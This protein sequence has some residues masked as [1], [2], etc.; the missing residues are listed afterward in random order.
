MMNNQNEAFLT[1]NAD[2]ED[3]EETWNRFSNDS[4]S[5]QAEFLQYT[6]NELDDI[7][8]DFTHSKYSL[9]EAVVLF[10]AK[11]P[12]NSTKNEIAFFGETRL[13]VCYYD[14]DGVFLGSLK[15]LYSIESV[16]FD[17]ITVGSSLQD[18]IALDPNGSY[19]FLYT[20]RND[21][22]KVS[23]HYTLDK[24]EVVITYDENNVVQEVKKT[25][26]A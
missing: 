4:Q 6:D 17:S 15:K 23:M 16:K 12:E 3:V 21:L 22:P 11:S 18:V 13:L 10:D 24:Q 2:T 25:P 8:T 7:H 14:V 5:N 26:F 1:Q 20:G 9:S 19:L